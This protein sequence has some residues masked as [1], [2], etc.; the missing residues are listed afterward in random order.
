MKSKQGV[1][2]LIL[3]IT[4]IVILLLV[5][6]ISVISGNTVNNSRIATFANDLSEIEDA[7]KIYYMQNGK[8]PTLDEKEY[9]KDDILGIV[10]IKYKGK[11]IE[12]LQSNNDENKTSFYKV[13]LTKLD[14]EQTS[15]G[16]Q[17]DDNGNFFE[18][19]VYV[20]AYPSMR[21][22][23]LEG[24]RAKNTIFFSLTSK[25]T[26]L[27]KIVVKETV[28]NGNTSITT[29]NG[30]IIRKQN[31]KW[32]NKLG[33]IIESNMDE[34]EALYFEIVDGVRHKI[35]T[36]KGQNILRFVDDFSTITNAGGQNQNTGVNSN[37]LSTFNS[38]STN[39][40]KLIITKELDGNV[41][42][43]AEILLSNYETG[44]PSFAGEVNVS[45]KEEY[46]LVTLNV[47]D[48]ISGISEVM[49]EYITRIDEEGNKV[50]YY[51]GIDN[52]D[53]DYMKARAKKAT[54]SSNG[55]IEIKV[56]KDVESIQ[57]NAFDKSG[58]SS[59]PLTVYTI[60]EV[61]IG[62]NEKY[63]TKTS[64]DLNNIVKFSEKFDI[65]NATIEI[66]TDGVNYTSSQ[67]IN[68]EYYKDGI[69]K[70][71]VKCENLIG[72]KDKLYVKLSI[73]YGENKSYARIKEIE[74][75]AIE[76]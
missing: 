51:E 61:Y 64:A 53:E 71:N 69:Y 52:F 8:L 34:N 60:S 33:L 6:T 7:V 76:N 39:D 21:L 23:Y 28:E 24:L 5:G 11:F 66:S 13:D 62:I 45:T 48:T 47:V 36:I 42:G 2:L 10:P 73:N 16:L 59:E 9:S 44:K 58:N 55:F 70:C 50:Q 68:F 4:I 75:N 26:S 30:I 56:P 19:D 41:I 57:L 25:I 63:A 67:P 1:T 14:V 35:N 43:K 32:T 29:S 74:I 46:N 37:E 31:N 20:V 72:V 17:K 49:Y 12:E 27:T 22:Y 3:I 38:K 65:N 54:V 18:S 15:R 40:R